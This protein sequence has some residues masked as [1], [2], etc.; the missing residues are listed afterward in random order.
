MSGRRILLTVVPLLLFVGAMGGTYAYYA[1]Q[2]E[3][4]PAASVAR[5][6]LGTLDAPVRVTV[7]TDYEC[8][9]CKDFHEKYYDKLKARY[10][11]QV[12]VVYKNFPRAEH[13]HAYQK[14]LIAE[15][16]ARANG[17]AAYWKYVAQLFLKHQEKWETATDEDGF[18]AAREIGLD[19]TALRTCVDNGETKK[20][21]D[22][23]IADGK[24]RGAK[25]TPAVLIEGAGY[26]SLNQ[27]NRGTGTGT[28]IEYIRTL[29][30]TSS[31]QIPKN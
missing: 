5:H 11:K 27:G 10:G 7:Y 24:A 17:E 25:A 3:A 28:A 2:T 30:A 13:F 26:S 1:G 9:H 23:D 18:D 19:D 4:H 16:V 29:L 31:Q 14:A 8:P 15:C 20:I 6:I 21:V 22:A 12:V